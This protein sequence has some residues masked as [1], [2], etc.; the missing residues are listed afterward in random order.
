MSHKF[1]YGGGQAYRLYHTDHIHVH[2]LIRY[3][4]YKPR[5]HVPSTPDGERF[6]APGCA[7]IG[8]RRYFPDH[9]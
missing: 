5:K 2:T 3:F 9:F 6:D 7:R 1:G 8:R 4:E